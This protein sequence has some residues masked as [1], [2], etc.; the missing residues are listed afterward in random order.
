MAVIVPPG[1]D[2]LATLDEMYTIKVSHSHW[3]LRN[4][5]WDKHMYDV[6]ELKRAGA[7]LLPD[8]YN[9]LYPVWEDLHGKKILDLTKEA[10]DFFA[11]AVTR[12][13]VHDTLHESVSYG[14]RPMYEALLRDGKSVQLDMTKLKALPFADQV[15][16]FREEIY[17]TA[18]ER[19]VIPSGYRHSPMRAYTWALRRT[20]TGLTKG[21]SSLFLIENYETFARR[22][23]IDYVAKHLS[24]KH[25]LIHRDQE[26]QPA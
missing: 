12:V 6:V 21:W 8:M 20:I 26:A 7:R 25:K 9:T 14:E 13:Y 5:S 3:E 15:K 19:L 22:P 24:N 10:E 18:L 23:D 17:V 1:T 2:R 4:G 16:L 11:D